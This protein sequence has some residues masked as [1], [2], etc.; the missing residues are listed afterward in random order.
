MPYSIK[1]RDVE[2]YGLLS[3]AKK[4]SNKYRKS[5]IRQVTS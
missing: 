3:F 2:E 1:P 5:S 4:M